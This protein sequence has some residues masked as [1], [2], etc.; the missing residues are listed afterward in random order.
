MKF[1]KW[2]ISLAV[3]G[4]SY[5]VNAQTCNSQLEATTPTSNFTIS[6]NGTVTD[7]QTGLMWKRCV[8]GLSGSICNTGIATT[9]TWQAA[10]NYVATLNNVGFAGYKDW[11]LPNI[12][13]LSSIVELKCSSPLIN[14]TVFP[15]TSATSNLWSS[16]VRWSNEV[17]FLGNS[18]LNI[19]P[20][21][22]QF[23]IRLVR[24]Q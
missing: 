1:N 14:L 19:A 4:L 3:I 11:R 20:Q 12:K 10:L 2:L 23:Y 7:N 22:E 6:N 8:E 17:A 24:G 13:E 5:N 18:G 15:N 9:Y 16:T 21:T